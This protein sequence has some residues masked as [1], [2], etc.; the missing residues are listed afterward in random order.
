MPLAQ[1]AELAATLP[2][3]PQSP[4]GFPARLLLPLQRRLHL[5]KQRIKFTGIQR[6]MMSWSISG[7]D[8][9]SMVL[10]QPKTGFWIGSVPVGNRVAAGRGTP[11]RAWIK[12]MS[13]G[14]HGGQRTSFLANTPL[15]LILIHFTL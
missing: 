7:R 1:D 2:E 11:Y 8:I 5:S 15:P 9:H 13:F 12:C 3:A 6:R 10:P 14:L 4:S